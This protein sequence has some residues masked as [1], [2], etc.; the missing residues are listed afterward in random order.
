MKKL[1][2]NIDHVATLREIRRGIEPEPVFA[3]LLC[4]S[5]GADSIVVHLR[6]DRRHI[7]ERDLYV[8]KEVVKSKLNVEMSISR[9]IVAIVS[10]VK[11]DQVTL[12]PE[13]RHELTTEGGLDVVSNFKK[14]KEVVLRLE[15]RG[16]PVSLFMDPD[17]KQIEYAKKLGIKKLELHTGR[18]AEAKNKNEIQESLNEI[19]TAANFAKEKKFD[20]YAGHGLNYFNVKEIVDIE[21]IE[22]LNIGYAIICRSVIVGLAQAVRDMKSLLSL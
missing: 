17:R 20:V 8:L 4:E 18:Y 21:I 3:A 1:G 2:V 7:K 15:G 6:E 19:R 14:I 10:G 12:V 13:K 16:I 22:E 9:D 11:P 5:A